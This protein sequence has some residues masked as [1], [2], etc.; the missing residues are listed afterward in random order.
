[1]MMGKKEA[2][3]SVIYTD[4]TVRC[5]LP[6]GSS[7]TITLTDYKDLIQIARV[8][9][10]DEVQDAPED[11]PNVY[12]MSTPRNLISLGIVTRKDRPKAMRILCLYPESH[13]KLVWEATKGSNKHKSFHVRYPRILLCHTLSEDKTT[14][15]NWVWEDT[16]YY[17]AVNPDPAAYLDKPSLF[18][19]GDQ[20]ACNV[21]RLPFNNAYGDGN[22]CYGSVSFTRTFRMENL[23][24][25]DWMY[26]L[27]VESVYNTDLDYSNVVV[28]LDK[29]V[30]LY[31]ELG[32]YKSRIIGLG[33][34]WWYGVLE[35]FETF[36]YDLLT[37]ID[38]KRAPSSV[39]VRGILKEGVASGGKPW[40]TEGA[41]KYLKELDEN[42]EIAEEDREKI[43]ALVG[44]KV[45]RR[46]ENRAYAQSLREQ[47]RRAMDREAAVA[48]EGA[49]RREETLVQPRSSHLG[50]FGAFDPVALTRG[51]V[52][53]DFTAGLERE[54][55]TRQQQ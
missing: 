18:S 51:T 14:P 42:D 26:Q 49:H 43:L 34:A 1:M 19:G 13:H 11:A 25:L 55:W 31:P 53:I 12:T 5:S 35:Q 46:A 47:R 38:V 2:L 32:K 8:E 7:K 28:D 44:D 20:S 45:A 29:C 24:Q 17:T 23:A 40:T 6:G 15:G 41:L 54:V 36:P 50:L 4:G 33:S 3:S 9:T 22:L 52:N 37:K 27:L 21:M 10:V 30:A 16:K 39:A 48:V